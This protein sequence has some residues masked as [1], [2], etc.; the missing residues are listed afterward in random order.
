MLLILLQLDVFR[1]VALFPVHPDADKAL[2]GNLAEQALM[3]AL[4]AGDDRRKDLQPGFLG[5]LHNPVHHLF[6]RLGRDLDPVLGAVRMSDTG[7]KKAKIV[8]NLGDRADGGARVAA[9]RLLV[10]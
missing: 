9:R 3:L 7:K 1:E 8:V 4:L 10:D 5:I 6:H 2:L